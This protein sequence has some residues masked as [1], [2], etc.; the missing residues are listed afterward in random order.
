VT[1][2]RSPSV[3]RNR[4][5]ILAVLAPLCEA[6]RAARGPS[7]A[8]VEIAAGSGEHSVY[9]AS[10]L[11][12]V[13]WQPSDRDPAS[14]A[15]IAAARAEEGPPNLLAPLRVDARAEV[16]LEDGSQ[17]GLVCINMIH[18]SPWEATLGLLRSAGRVLREG[19][20]ALLYGPYREGGK[21][22]AESNARFDAEL[23][24]RDPS[25]GVRDLDDVTHAAAEHGLTLERRVEMPRDNLCVVFR[26]GRPT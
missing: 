22:T 18:I 15:S 20:F 11:P 26:R 6:E 13:A 17:D 19:G 2:L 7:L 4:D 21:H 1:R 9:F 23:R 24:V 3:A 14:L 10:K 16:P 12:Y 5:P 8:V 25:W